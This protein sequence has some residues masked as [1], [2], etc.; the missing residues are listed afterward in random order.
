MSSTPIQ[1]VA[2]INLGTVNPR[3]VTFLNKKGDKGDTGP[4]GKDAHLPTDKELIKLLTPFIPPAIPGHTPTDKELL[5]LIRPLIPIVKDGET[6]SDAKLLSLI[7]PLIPHVE[8]GKRGPA[9][10]DGKDGSPDTAEEIIGKINTSKDKIELKRIKDI[11]TVFQGAQNQ[12]LTLPITFT[13]ETPTA[14]ESFPF[15]ETGDAIRITSVSAILKGG[16]SVTFNIQKRL[17]TAVNSTGTN[18]LASS[19]V[20]TQTWGKTTSLSN[21]LIPADAYLVFVTSAVSG[22]SSGNTITLRLTYI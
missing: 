10:K 20:T 19:M 4:A 1:K 15:F 14:T 6:P 17:K 2:L 3:K 21:A 22:I 8:D 16:T 9:G 5:K 12:K 7:R 18:I 11:E 13:L